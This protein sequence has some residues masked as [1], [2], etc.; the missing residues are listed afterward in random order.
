MT[1]G[2]NGNAPDK[3]IGAVKKNDMDNIVLKQKLMNLKQAYEFRDE[4]CKSFL[5]TNL[6]LVLM[7]N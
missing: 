1:L 6:P 7:S 5:M 3:A 2:V 4:A